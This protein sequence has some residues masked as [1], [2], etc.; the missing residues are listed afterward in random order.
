MSDVGCRMSDVGC[1]MS[2]VGCPCTLSSE[3]GHASFTWRAESVGSYPIVR[4]ETYGIT[5]R[6][7]LGTNERK[8]LISGVH[9]KHISNGNLKEQNLKVKKKSYWNG[10][11]RPTLLV[12]VFI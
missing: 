3:V 2:D 1:R 9:G 6:L 8:H 11:N 7:I 10:L 12:K 5:M 4:S